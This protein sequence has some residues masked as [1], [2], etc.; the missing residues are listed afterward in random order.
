MIGRF[1]SREIPP[2]YKPRN[3]Q[4]TWNRHLQNH[5]YMYMYPNYRSSKNNNFTD[6]TGHIIQQN[7]RP[8]KHISDKREIYLVLVAITLVDHITETCSIP[9]SEKCA[10]SFVRLAHYTLAIYQNLELSPKTTCCQCCTA[11]FLY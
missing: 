7:L 10:C 6:L 8:S 2:E 3:A 5:I 1:F 9:I 11:Q 4:C